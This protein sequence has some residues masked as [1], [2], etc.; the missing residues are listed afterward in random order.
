MKI[1]VKRIAVE[2]ITALRELHRQEMNCQIVHDS[3]P[4]RGFSDPYLIQL[5]GRIAGYCLVANRY[6]P[7]M[8]DEFYV[9][10]AYRGEALPIFRQVLALSGATKIRAQTNDRLMLLMLYDC[11]RNIKSDT[12][13]FAD[14]FKSHLSCPDGVSLRRTT[15]AEKEQLKPLYPHEGVGEWLLETADGVVATGGALYHYNP[16]FGDIYMEVDERYR[17]RGYGSYLVQEVKRLC[18]EIGKVPA[19]RCNV[20]NVASRRTL[21]KA[22]LL[23]CGRILMGDVIK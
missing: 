9:A 19:A 14:G 2:D 10:P 22:G 1:D 17:Q 23:P 6:E 20:S 3:F 11:A 12:I 16:P 7:D 21:E 4:G 13:L 8:V 15:D 5:D 18:Y